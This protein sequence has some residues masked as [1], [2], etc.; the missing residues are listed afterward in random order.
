M[1]K[2]LARPLGSAICWDDGSGERATGAVAWEVAS[3]GD[4]DWSIVLQDDAVPIPGFLEHAADA[5]EYAEG[6]LV[7]F[8]VGTGRGR[9][10]GVVDAIAG[11][12]AYNLAWLGCDALLWGVALALPTKLVPEMLEATAQLGLRYDT[13]IGAWAAKR[14]IPIRYTWPS[15]VDHADVPSIAQAGRKANPKIPGSG[16]PPPRHAHRVGVPASW[17]TGVVQIA[18]QW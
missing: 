4:P 5:L 17:D 6:S 13:R 1:A 14:S 16:T 15:L 7:S 18:A 10:A 12:D 9:P 3:L 11:A 8:Y 2:D